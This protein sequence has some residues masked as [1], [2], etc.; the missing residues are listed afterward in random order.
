MVRRKSSVLAVA[1]L[2]LLI[3]TACGGGGRTALQ[4]AAPVQPADNTEQAVPPGSGAEGSHEQQNLDLPPLL[5]P[6]EQQI[7][8]GYPTWTD[9][10][11]GYTW[12]FYNPTELRY[13]EV[14][15]KPD[16]WWIEDD[17]PIDENTP[18]WKIH[19]DAAVEELISRGYGLFPQYNAMLRV[20]HWYK[21]ILPEGMT[22]FDVEFVWPEEFP[23]IDRVTPD[24]YIWLF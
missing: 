11:D 14:I 17:Y 20:P 1:I 16:E 19:E 22:F 3:F 10:R 13:T 18:P 8:P 21:V 9:P 7:P 12:V 23:C 4:P 15:F 6:W 2:M 5:P 24:I